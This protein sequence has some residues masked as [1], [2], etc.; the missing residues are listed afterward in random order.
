M[1]AEQRERCGFVD[2]LWVMCEPDMCTAIPVQHRYPLVEVHRLDTDM[3]H[4]TP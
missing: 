2:L 3:R 4:L 1:H